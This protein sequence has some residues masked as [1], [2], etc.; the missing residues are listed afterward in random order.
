[1]IRSKL[2]LESVLIDRIVIQHEIHLWLKNYIVNETVPKGLVHDLF[3]L[4][5]SLYSEVRSYSQDVVKKGNQNVASL[6]LF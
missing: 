5:T 3:E 1:M 2:H 6:K 4:S